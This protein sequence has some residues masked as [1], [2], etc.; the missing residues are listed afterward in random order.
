MIATARQ[1]PLTLALTLALAG[2]A[3]A[4]GG[5]VTQDRDTLTR[6]QIEAAGQSTAL[7]VIRS[8]RPQWL[9]ERGRHSITNQSDVAVYLDGT[10]LGGPGSLSGIAAMDIERMR[11]HSASEAQLKWGTGHVHG[12][13]EVITR[14]N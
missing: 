3:T 7:D 1:A 2:C 11:Y 6:A 4:G 12:A 8:E 9:R 14:R 13:I 5:G 10:R